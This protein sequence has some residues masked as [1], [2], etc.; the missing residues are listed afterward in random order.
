MKGE[1][2]LSYGEEVTIAPS[3]KF[4]IDK[5]NPDVSYEWRVDGSLLPDETG[6]SC[7]ISFERGGTYELTFTVVDNKRWC[8]VLQRVVHFGCVLRLLADG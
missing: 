7:T 8:K 2:L 3:F 6:A 4:S 5:E 1:Y